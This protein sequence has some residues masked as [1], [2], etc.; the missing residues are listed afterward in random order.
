M[1]TAAVQAM[2]AQATAAAKGVT[3]ALVA[4]EEV[5]QAAPVAV[6]AVRVVKA[7]FSLIKGEPNSMDYLHS[8]QL[9]AARITI[10]NVGNLQADFTENGQAIEIPVQ[11]V[12]IQLP[13][14][15]VLVDTCL[16]E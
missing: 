5:T 4:A 1:I 10:I 11:S 7:P 14:T 8:F 12:L 6:T 3:M 9:G 15:I 16:Y 13:E 2:T